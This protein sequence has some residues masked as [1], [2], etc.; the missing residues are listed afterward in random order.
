MYVGSLSEGSRSKLPCDG[1]KQQPLDK[2]DLEILAMERLLE[3]DLL[4][5][6]QGNASDYKTRTTSDLL[7][8]RFG[9]LDRGGAVS[10]RKTFSKTS[11]KNRFEDPFL[12]RLLNSSSNNQDQN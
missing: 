12:N 4:S 5:H 10:K 3:E 8:G 11:A 6:S 9:S 2:K 1:G 7:A